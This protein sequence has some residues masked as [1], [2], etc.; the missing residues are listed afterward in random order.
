MREN[1]TF[2]CNKFGKTTEANSREG[3]VREMSQE[4]ET[5]VK[6]H[7]EQV[8]VD[9]NPSLS[10]IHTFPPTPLS[11]SNIPPML[12]LAMG[13]HYIYLSERKDLEGEITEGVW[14]E[15]YTQ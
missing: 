14:E 3:K 13:L 2:L 5:W 4:T 1:V 11:T 12:D 15:R 10:K 8:Q 6:Q 9:L 7:S